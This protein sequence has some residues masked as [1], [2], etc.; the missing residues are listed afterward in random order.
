MSLTT[1]GMTTWVSRTGWPVGGP[2]GDFLASG[3]FTPHLNNPPSAA[4]DV[5]IPAGA[6]GG[7]TPLDPLTVIFQEPAVGLPAALI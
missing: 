3:A 7:Q 1:A 5:W 6:S 4:D 2:T